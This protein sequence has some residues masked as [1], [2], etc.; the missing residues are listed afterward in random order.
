MCARHAGIMSEIPLA[1][2][3]DAAERRLASA[4]EPEPDAV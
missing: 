3:L 1:E 4:R 2:V